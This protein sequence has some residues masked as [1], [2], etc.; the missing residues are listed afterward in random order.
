MFY[1][2]AYVKKY[3]IICLMLISTLKT[4]AEERWAIVV[5]VSEYPE[6][7][8]WRSINGA[9][10]IPL[11][12]SMLNRL[13]FEND[14]VTILK[15]REAT[16]ANIKQAF[17]ILQNKLKRGDIV[18]FHF[19]GHGQRVVD[20]NGDEGDMGKDESLIPYDAECEY[21]PGKYTGQN[22][23]IDDELNA[24]LWGLKSKIGN[25]GSIIV[26][27][28]ACHSGGASRL[29]DDEEKPPHRGVENIF[30]LPIPVPQKVE[31][32]TPIEWVC[33]SACKSHEVNWEYK[34]EEGFYCGRLSYALNK[35]FKTNLTWDQINNALVVEYGKMPLARTPQHPEVELPKS[36]NFKQPIVNE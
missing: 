19:S 31:K 36:F 25:D 9:N 27:I 8:G 33:I 24:W 17:I 15:D 5:G 10:D 20:V 29:E 28:D 35:M 30:Q 16:K 34:T 22:H 18:Y 1:N 2:F 6:S 21:I 26:S 3:L 32:Q 12:V 4:Y 7:S 23:I 11:I 13:G 14:N